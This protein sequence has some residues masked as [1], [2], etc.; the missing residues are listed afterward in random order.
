MSDVDQQLYVVEVDDRCSEQ[1]VGHTGCAYASPPHSPGQALSL[2][3]VVLGCPQREL[4]A[5][6]GPWS[7]AIAGGRRTIRLHRVQAGGQLVL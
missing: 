2:V 4:R 3:R 6:H 5:D 1:P 7:C